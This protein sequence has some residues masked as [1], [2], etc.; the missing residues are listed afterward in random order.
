MMM[1]QWMRETFPPLQKPPMGLGTAPIGGLYREITE[2]EAIES[3]QRAY[4][5]GVRLFDSA[6]MYGCGRSEERTGLALREIPRESYTLSTKI[7]RLLNEARDG[8]T[9]DYSYDGIM[10]CLEG[11]LSRLRTDHVE[12]LHI[13]EPDPPYPNRQALTE[14]Y[15]TLTKLREEGVIRAVGAGMNTWADL[16][17]LVED[18]AY[19][20]DLFLLAGRYTLLEQGA[21]DFLSLCQTHQ[22]GIFAAGV[23]NSGILATG[24]S[25]PDAKYNYQSAP[26]ALVEKAIEIERICHHNNVRLNQ[27]AVQFVATHPAMSAVVIGAETA[28]QV[29]ANWDAMN[30]SIPEQLWV[31]LREEG[32]ITTLPGQPHQ[33]LQPL[34]TFSTTRLRAKA[35]AESDLDILCQ[36]HL[37]SDVMATLGGVRSVEV[38]KRFIAE[39]IDHWSTH[40]FGYWIFRENDTGEFVGRAGLQHIEIGGNQE[41]EIGYTVASAQWGKGYATEMATALVDIAFNRLGITELI[42]F[43][44]TS[45][46]ASQRV[47][48]KV[49]FSFEREILHKEEPHVLCRLKAQT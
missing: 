45:N 22:V 25:D 8:W 23:Y 16:I 13:H 26:S 30:A 28:E 29:Q 2:A 11:S 27:A 39:K 48:E 32:L 24:P 17:E 3:V 47:M 35:F 36:L 46:L 44:L 9:M 37:D 18:D 7:G 34:Q 33:T 41:I 43:T 15:P 12:I 14:A 19:Q 4:S 20:F 5:L 31:D 21:A 49:G 10:R 40:G 1:N 38:T 6:P 42:C